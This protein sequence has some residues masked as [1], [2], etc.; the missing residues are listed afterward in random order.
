MG[1]MEPS[2]AVGGNANLYSYYGEYC[3]DSLKNWEY[4]PTIPLLGLHPKE[5]RIEREFVKVILKQILISPLAI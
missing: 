1:K 3:G 4:N 5:T 2:Y